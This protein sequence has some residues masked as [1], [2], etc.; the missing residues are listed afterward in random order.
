MKNVFSRLPKKLISAVV[1][2]LV[3]V[4][5]TAGAMAGFG[6]DRPTIAWTNNGQ[7]FDH[8]TFNSFTGVPSVGD[9]RDFVRG[10]QVARDGQWTDPVAGVTQD[11]EIEAKVFI[12]NGAAPA[13]NDQPGNPGVA[14]NVT[15]KVALP[16]G[17][18]TAQQINASITADNAKPGT[19]TDTLDLTGADGGAFEVE[20]VAGS[21]KLHKNGATTALTAAQEQAMIAGGVNLGDQKGCFEFIQEITFRVKV[22]MPQ[23]KIT[24]SVR[25]EGQTS[26]DWVKSLNDVKRTDTVE[27]KLEFD[28][29]GKTQLQDVVLQD[30]LPPFVTIVP[31]TVTMYDSNFPAGY[32]FADSQAIQND[33]KRLNLTIGNVNAGINSIVVFKTKVADDNSIKCGTHELYNKAY[34]T[35]KNFGSVSDVAYIYIVNAEKCGVQGGETPAPTFVCNSL[36]VNYVNKADRKVTFTAKATGT[37]GAT[38][39]QFKVDTGKTSDASDNIIFTDTT[40]PEVTYPKD[41]HEFVATLTVD[42]NVP[43]QGVKTTPVSDVCK[44]V[45]KFDAPI[46]P[47]TVK[48]VTTTTPTV[49]PNTGVGAVIGIFAGATVA[50]AVT[51]RLIAR[52]LVR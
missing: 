25:R 15:V 31:G 46:T 32:K 16:S 50:G 29:I 28:N 26:K 19:V 12:H 47:A 22:K 24:K 40:S 35:P 1:S 36:S 2:V 17:S 23:Y 33:G 37:N 4:G 13:L 10:V 14:K 18:K 20:Y 34:A 43:D 8:V 51:H 6:P 11:A 5:F 30:E 21:G 39:K 44:Q 52:K 49:L 45:V 48:P 41:K 27:W 38:V 42:F 3:L 7:G 9:E